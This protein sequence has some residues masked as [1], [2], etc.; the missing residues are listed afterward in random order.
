MSVD[1]FRETLGNYPLQPLEPQLTTSGALAV[2]I[3]QCCAPNKKPPLIVA[4]QTSPIAKNAWGGYRS[5]PSLSAGDGTSA[6]RLK[7]GRL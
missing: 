3:G 7:A 2:V 6:I 4:L 1:S 5:R